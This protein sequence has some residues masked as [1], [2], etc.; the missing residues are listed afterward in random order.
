MEE[1]LLSLA[2]QLIANLNSLAETDKLFVGIAGVRINV[3]F[4]NRD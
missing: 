2:Q 3:C 4:V 1:R